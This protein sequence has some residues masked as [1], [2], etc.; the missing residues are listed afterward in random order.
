[1]SAAFERAAVVLACTVPS[2]Y[3]RAGHQIDPETLQDSACKLAMTA[4]HQLAREVGRGPGGVD[5]V[6]QRLRR[7][8]GEGKITL[9]AYDAARDLFID[10]P[11]ADPNAVM[12]ELVAQLQRKLRREAAYSAASEMANRGDM[13]ATAEIIERA[14]NLGKVDTVTLGSKFGVEAFDAITQL[15]TLERLSTGIEDLDEAIGGGLWRGA[16]GVAVGGAG[17][18]KSM[19]LSGAIS[20]ALDKRRSVGLITLELPEALQIARVSASLFNIPVLEITEGDISRAR[21]ML[22]AAQHRLGRLR[23]CEMAAQATNV[24]DVLDW[25]D[26]VEQADGAAMELLVVDYADKLGTRKKDSSSYNTGLEVYEGLRLFAQERGKY[27]WTASQSRGRK[28]E[29]GKKAKVKDL[30]DVADSMHK[31]RVADLVITLNG[32][33][34]ELTGERNMTMFVAKHRIGEGRQ[35]VG[36]LPTSFAYGRLVG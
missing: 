23:V 21:G 32:E 16:L 9:D 4:A 36:P 19:F 8:N 14:K 13:S 31:V 18:G 22:A 33:E 25:V 5:V 11:P 10:A 7:W 15:R 35:K 1:L 24:K 29:G 6:L 12:V 30:G 34:D 28:E 2:F 17:D 27:C 20:C 26:R 3:G